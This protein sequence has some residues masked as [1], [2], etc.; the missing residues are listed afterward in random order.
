[1]KLRLLAALLAIVSFS[2][3]ANTLNTTVDV[4]TKTKTVQY[5]TLTLT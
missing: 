4:S 2:A 5:S 3:Q 1:M